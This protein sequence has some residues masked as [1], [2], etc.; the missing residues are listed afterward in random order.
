MYIGFI[1]IITYLVDFSLLND[2]WWKFLLLSICCIGINVSG[3]FEGCAK[4]EYRIY[5][6][7]NGNE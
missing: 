4:T 3:Y 6:I 1:T 5:T 2:T 7:E